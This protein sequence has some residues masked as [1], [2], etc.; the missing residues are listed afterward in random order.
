M[1]AACHDTLLDEAERG[2]SVWDYISPSRLNLW[3]RCPLA[4]RFRYIDGIVTPPTASLF[5]GKQVH[6]GLEVF[7]RHRQLGLDL[8]PEEVVARMLAGW[9]EAVAEEQIKF[10]S[11]NEEAET[12]DQASRLVTVYLSQRDPDE[13]TPVAV[14][15]SLEAPLVDPETGEDLGMPL[16]GVVDLVLD[17]GLV[18]DFK[19]AA[20]TNN[21]VEIL[22]EVQ[23]SAY[24]WL[25]RQTTGTRESGLEI[26]S[27]VKTK[28]PK[29]ETHSY[30]ARTERDYRRFFRLVRA[31][32][33]DLHAG[34]V[35]HRPG[36]HCGMCEYGES[37]AEW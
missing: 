35:T 33:D 28:V 23:L 16:L 25:F 7:Y 15:T 29:V 11:G 4:W 21:P 26:R 20:K 6:A 32:M 30:A 5:L 22:H 18:V 10:A 34:R 24:S 37:C 27:L 13:P 1:S 12:R 9:D 2:S 31:Y 19:T 36:F 14:E 3:L 17:G 8:P